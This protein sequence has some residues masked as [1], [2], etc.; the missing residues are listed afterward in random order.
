MLDRS[1]GLSENFLKSKPPA[2]LELPQALPNFFHQSAVTHDLPCLAPPFILVC[3][4]EN[5]GGTAISRND[6]LFLI[7]FAVSHKPAQM[8]LG[9]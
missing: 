1:Q 9:F 3:A 7:P 4:Y 6:K 2:F 5:S 8:G